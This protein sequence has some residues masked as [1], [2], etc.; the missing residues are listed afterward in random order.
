MALKVVHVL[1]L[2]TP[3]EEMELI[4]PCFLSETVFLN[5]CATALTMKF[6][7]SALEW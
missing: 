2:V 5:K 1:H 7:N 3:N 6:K 4:A